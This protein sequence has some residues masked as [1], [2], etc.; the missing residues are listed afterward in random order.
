[1]VRRTVVLV[2]ALAAIL[3]APGSARPATGV[4]PNGATITVTTDRSG[5]ISAPSTLDL[6][7][8]LA[9]GDGNASV[10]VSTSTS[11]TASGAPAGKTVGSCASGSLHAAAEPGTYTCTVATILMRPGT[12]YHWWLAYTHTADG[13]LVGQSEVSGPFSFALQDPAASS[14]K[15]ESVSTKTRESAALLPSQARFTGARSIKHATLTT[16]VA[17]TMK[18]A[19][20][21]PRTL[22]VACWTRG[23]FAAVLA[24][25]GQAPSRGFV[26]T[27]GMWFRSQP[28]WL[29]LSQEACARAQRLLDT[30]GT[31]W[32]DADGLVTPL[33]EAMHATGIS[34]EA[35]ANCL[36]VQLTPL[37]ASFAG[38]PQ[39]RARRLGALALAYTRETAPRDYWDAKRCRDG[40]AWDIDPHRANLR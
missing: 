8:T 21:R 26:D 32:F 33:H 31:T 40:G 38:L 17:E 22:A 11:R 1:M 6:S 24:A 39:V 5:Y 19:G 29:H 36:A 35:Q 14:A 2:A 30:K 3:L 28:H 34:N 27:T 9:S 7:V 18:A 25:V 37:A 16:I 4:G 13:S 12:T 15:R 20:R 23:D 10:W